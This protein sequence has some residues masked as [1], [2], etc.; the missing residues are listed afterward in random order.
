L[1]AFLC[2][3]SKCLAVKA[4][5]LRPSWAWAVA[6]GGKRVENRSWYSAHRGALL[7]HAG[8]GRDPDA[9]V[10]RFIARRRGLVAPVEF[11]Q[12]V[13]VARVDLHDVVPIDDAAIDADQYAYATGPYLWL[14]RN[15]VPVK[16]IE[17]RG[18]QGIFDVG[19]L[20]VRAL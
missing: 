10:V 18:R 19:D 17:L 1:P 8:S 15:V 13:I 20:R 12:G 11:A 5:T 14:L 3:A 16:P 2:L 9:E 7:I 4:L 6:F